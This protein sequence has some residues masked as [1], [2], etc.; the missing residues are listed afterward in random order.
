MKLSSLLN[1]ENR[2]TQ[3]CLG[4]DKNG[5]ALKSLDTYFVAKFDKNGKIFYQEFKQDELAV[6][7]SLYGAVVKCCPL[8]DHENTMHKLS[9]AIRRYTGKNLWVAQF[10]DGLDTKFEDIKAVLKIANV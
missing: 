2:W 3:H 4:R 8:D 5:N 7:Y 10:N 1:R 6:S 9:E